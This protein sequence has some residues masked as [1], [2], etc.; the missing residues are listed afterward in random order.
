MELDL[1]DFPSLLKKVWEYK[2][3]ITYCGWTASEHTTP[4]FSVTRNANNTASAKAVEASYI[5][6]LATSMP[7]KRVT[8]VWYS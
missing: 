7:S 5:D 6:A 2:F 3:K 4:V 8:W 1:T